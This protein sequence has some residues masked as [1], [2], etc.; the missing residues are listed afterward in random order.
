M[1]GL[2]SEQSLGLK[3]LVSGPSVARLYNKFLAASVLLAVLAQACVCE[4]TNPSRLV[5]WGWGESKSKS[6]AELHFWSVL[7]QDTEPQSA[8]EGTAM[9]WWLVQGAPRLRLE[10]AGIGSSNKPPHDPYEKRDKAVTDDDMTRHKSM[11]NLPPR[12][13]KPHFGTDMS[14]FFFFFFYLE[15]T[16]QKKKW[17]MLF[18]WLNLFFYFFFIFLR[19]E[20]TAGIFRNSRKSKLTGEMSLKHLSHRTRTIDLFWGGPPLPPTLTAVSPWR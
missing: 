9:S 4:P 7:E 11:E 17:I 18:E 6:W 16:E 2:E 3:R 20:S 15:H 19:S 12:G 10:T 14:F 1:Q 5:I 8:P 13:L